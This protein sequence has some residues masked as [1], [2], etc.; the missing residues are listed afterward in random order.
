MLRQR[1]AEIVPLYKITADRLQ[2]EQL[3]MLLYALGDYLFI[4][5]LNE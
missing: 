2:D 5:S 3:L 4:N 1:F